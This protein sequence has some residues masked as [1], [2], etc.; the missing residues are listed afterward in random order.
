[1]YNGK[2][3]S[4]LFSSCFSYDGTRATAWNIPYYW[5]R[6]SI[7]AIRLRLSAY[8]MNEKLFSNLIDD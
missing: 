1:M 3:Y 5:L 7:L 6:L 8:W 4:N 2:Y